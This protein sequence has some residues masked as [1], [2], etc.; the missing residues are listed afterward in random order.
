MLGKLG[1]NVPN[2]NILQKLLTDNKRGVGERQVLRRRKAALG[3]EQTSVVSPLLLHALMKTH[4]EQLSSL[5]DV[6]S[7]MQ[8]YA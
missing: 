8:E 3:P 1:A 4:I 5:A 6:H 2:L 7:P